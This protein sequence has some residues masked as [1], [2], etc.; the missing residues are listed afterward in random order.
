MP[1]TPP[2]IEKVSALCAR[3]WDR[4]YTRA[5]LKSDPVYAAIEE[6]LRG[7]TLP[8]LDIGCGIGL[9]T[10]WLRGCGIELPTVGID[11]DVRKITA[12]LHMAQGM[13]GVS[14]AT[15]DA[16]RDLPEHQGHVVILD[17]L[18]YFPAEE[19]DALLRAAAQRVAPGGRLLIRSGM[20]GGSWRYDLTRACDW[21]ARLT[22]W[23]KSSPVVYPNAAQFHRVLEAEGLSVVIKPL[24]GRTPFY[25]HLIRAERPAV[26]A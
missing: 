10:H 2:D 16:R 18:Q 26:P 24:W 9:L 22:R 15:G 4:H 6:D 3:R 12:A 17:V 23:M 1:L 25:N 8:V 13:S 11:F 19:Q 20:S 5:K 21:L 7:S 14:Y